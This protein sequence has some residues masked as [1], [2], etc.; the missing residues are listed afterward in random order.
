MISRLGQAMPHFLVGA[1]VA[2]EGMRERLRSTTFAF[3]GL[4]TAIG[5]ILVGIAYN[6]GWP[7]FVNSPIPGVPTERVGE[8]TIAA[9]AVH[10][11]AH[12][13]IAPSSPRSASAG[14]AQ[15]VPDR[16]SGPHVSFQQQVPVTDGHAPGPAPSGQGGAEAPA[17]P[18]PAP[19]APPAAAL[20]PT[21]PPPAAQP[22]AA[23]S[24]A[25]DQSPAKDPTPVA[26]S[27]PASKPVATVPGNGK[28]KGHEKSEKGHGKSTAPA[29]VVP[30]APSA[31]PAAPA[32]KA[33]PAST[34]PK[35]P[36]VATAPP[37]EA[38]P[39]ASEQPGKGHAYGHYK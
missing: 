9:D 29:S 6:Q 13:G 24:P 19:V 10:A 25:P 32:P 27:P 36:P 21:A 14:G 22:P 2:G 34:E 20:P 11:K 26:S 1:N 3:F 16:S 31:P 8:A 17:S 18:A 28:A 5:L 38:P 15:L 4:V 30:K 37:K 39:P 7:D 12:A 35:A 23:E 33:P